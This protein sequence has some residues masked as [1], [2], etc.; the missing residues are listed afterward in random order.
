[1]L[2]LTV[3]ARILIHVPS[4]DFRKGRRSLAVYVQTVL[5]EDP[6][7]KTL[8]LFCNKRKDCIKALYWDRTGF[9]MWE[10]EL[11]EQ[12]FRWPRKSDQQCISLTSEQ[13]CWLLDGIDISKLKPHKELKY[14]L[15][16]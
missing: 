12:K 6:F 14:Y 13:L 11:E 4:I 5:S 9:A 15:L 16:L 3:F 10:K 8:F 7:S 2:A 1:M